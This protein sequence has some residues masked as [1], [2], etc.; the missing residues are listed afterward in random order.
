MKYN[1]H[2]ARYVLERASAR[3]T[4]AR[5]AVGALAK[6]FLGEL[7]IRAEPCDRGGARA[8]G[9]AERGKNWSS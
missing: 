9:W 7:G 1:F 6:A 3:E 2:D 4:T 8:I 5:V